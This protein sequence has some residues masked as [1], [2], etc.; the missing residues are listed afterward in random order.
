MTATGVGEP[1]GASGAPGG[2][3]GP[4]SLAAA[5]VIFRV[6]LR[7]LMSGRRW[8]LAAVLDGLFVIVAVI[9]AVFAHDEPAQRYLFDL[10]RNLALPVLLPF[11][12]LIFSTDA[13]GTEV[14][15][16]T[17]IYLTLR[18]VPSWAIT[19]AKFAACSLVTVV[20]IWVALVPGFLVFNGAAGPR[21][22][23]PALLIG[24]VAGALAY[25][26]LFML[27]GLLV[28][29]A[30]LVGAVYILLWETALAALS[31]GAAHLSV[32][33]YALAIA[34]GVMRADYLI[35]DSIL[36][37]LPSL[38]TA[39]IFL[40]VVSALALWLTTRYVRRVELK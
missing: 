25:A 12:A 28:R 21:G 27:L 20:A 2:D 40:I 14:D 19:L 24:S 11:I 39:L 33:F 36:T 31:T 17:L 16:R 34:G 29:R 38:L 5:R 22:L 3:M 10:F 9:L 23:L 6:S 1:G 35:P 15:D 30:L 8:V 18:P 7:G 26:A 37:T 13:L 4:G 32:R